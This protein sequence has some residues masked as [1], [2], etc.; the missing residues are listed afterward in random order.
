MKIVGVGELLPRSYSCNNAPLEHG[1]LEVKIVLRQQVTRKQILQP[2]EQDAP[3]M[4]I[5][6]MFVVVEPD[7]A[8]AIPPGK[9]ATAL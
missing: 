7:L 9:A 1:T 4:T 2:G 8:V 6:P 3:Q 5:T